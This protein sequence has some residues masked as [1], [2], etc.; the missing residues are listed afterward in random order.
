MKEI[1]I[2]SDRQFII[3]KNASRR[4]LF[5]A[6]IHYQWLLEISHYDIS[7]TFSVFIL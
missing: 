2:I 5:H 3:F 6:N 4:F 1:S 7:K